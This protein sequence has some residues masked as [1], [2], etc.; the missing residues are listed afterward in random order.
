MFNTASH[1]LR[2]VLY[3]PELFR[4]L[5]ERWQLLV[6]EHYAR[7]Q[8]G[9]G[10]VLNWNDPAELIRRAEATMAEHESDAS[11]LDRFT[12]L[13]K[14]MLSSGQNLHHPHYIGHQVPAS[15]PVAGL[16]DAVGTMTNQ[17]MAIFEMGPWATAVEYAV[18]RRL[19]EKIGWNADESAGLLTHGGSLANLTA[20]LTAR[21]V[22]IPDSWEE[23]VPAG[24]VLVTH[25]DA[26]YCVSR[27]AGILGLGSKQI[28]RIGID[29][30]RRMRPELLD[31][32]LSRLKRD[33][34]SVMAVSCCACA[35]PTGAFDPID[36][37]AEVCE[38]HDVWLHVDAAHGGAALMSSTHRHL[39]KGIERADSVVWDAHK[40]LFVPALCAAVIYRRR[41]V[42]FETF[43]QNAP[44]L[45]DPSAPGMAEYDS[46]MR[47]IECTKR[48][49]GFGLWGLWSTVGETVFEQLVD[50]MF[51]LA[52]HLY[53]LVEAAPDFEPLHVPQCNI[54]VFQYRPAAMASADG[55]LLNRFQREI[56]S[57]LI[58]G[59]TF[60]IV[61]TQL[62]HHAGLRVTMMNPSTSVDDLRELLD[63]IRRIGSEVLTGAQWC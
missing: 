54:V 45:F 4:Q 1:D 16:F 25:P 57:R 13:V 52:R 15:A 12:S 49:T 5:S 27:T 61:Q 7:V 53:E 28:V 55:E 9:Q 2:T 22:R 10:P 62:G 21:N 60:Y 39:L 3:S 50:R 26:H 58:R 35:T 29:E 41:E 18:L 34:R 47:T 44:Y 40:M 42:R 24:T 17:V 6:S 43:R 63:E 36:Q 56:R 51:F 30:Q 46:G 19:A 48:A 32:E 11:I 23:G 38:R 14:L 20:L 37:I 31:Q 33:G 8:S 59:G